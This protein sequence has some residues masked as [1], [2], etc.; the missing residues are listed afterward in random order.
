M[1]RRRSD[2]L[3]SHESATILLQAF[4]KIAEQ[5]TVLHLGIRAMNQILEIAMKYNLTY[6]DASYLQ[7]C[8]QYNFTLVTED[9]K[10]T[11]AALSDSIRVM[12]TKKW[13]NES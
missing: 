9:E 10:L 4:E 2:E 7:C 5:S 8:S 6:Y 12:D 3:I 1:M 13:I 11:S